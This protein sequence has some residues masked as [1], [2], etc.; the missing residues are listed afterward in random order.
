M[1]LGRAEGGVAESYFDEY[2]SESIMTYELYL[3]P[4]LLIAF[5]GSL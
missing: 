1:I 4:R 3:N 5:F 2:W